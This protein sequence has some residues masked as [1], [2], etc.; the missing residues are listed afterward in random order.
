MQQETRPAP[1][2]PTV[3]LQ[4]RFLCKAGGGTCALWHGGAPDAAA[5]ATAR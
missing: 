5:A 1:A 3:S 2:R 4:E